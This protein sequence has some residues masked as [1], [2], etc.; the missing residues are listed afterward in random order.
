M[1]I[2]FNQQ[3]ADTRLS[4]A[5]TSKRVI[6]PKLTGILSTALALAS[7]AMPWFFTTAIN[8]TSQRRVD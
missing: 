8:R 4:R 3:A 5:K 7:H 1:W 2:F 6:N